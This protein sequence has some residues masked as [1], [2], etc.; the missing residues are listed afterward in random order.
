[1]KTVRQMFSPRDD[2]ELAQL[3]NTFGD[4][5]W[6]EVALRMSG[7]FTSRQC[8]ERWRNYLSPELDH[9][10]W[11][12]EDDRKLLR[13]FERCGTRW[14]LIAIGFPGRSGNAIRNRYF[15][16][17]RRKQR[18]VKG[19]MNRG[20]SPSVIF[21]NVNADSRAMPPDPPR[22]RFPGLAHPTTVPPLPPAPHEIPRLGA[23]AFPSLAPPA[24]L[25]WFGAEQF[26]ELGEKQS[27]TV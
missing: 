15:L 13:E 18:K 14:T 7:P 19:E 26:V 9:D 20:R 27:W 17:Q 5:N 6:G 10:R 8:R 22:I 3:I 16:L 1:M 24:G 12:D 23:L 25:S 2:E 11:T 4:G 21:A